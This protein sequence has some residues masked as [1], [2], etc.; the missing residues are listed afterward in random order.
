MKLDDYRENGAHEVRSRISSQNL[1]ELFVSAS[2]FSHD[3]SIQAF[4]PPRC[5]HS[6]TEF[7]EAAT[8]GKVAEQLP[9][10]EEQRVQILPLEEQANLELINSNSFPRDSSTSLPAA[11][12]TLSTDI[13]DAL[14]AETESP[15]SGSNALVKCKST[16][17]P[18]ITISR[19]DNDA[20][21]TTVTTECTDG[22]GCRVPWL[23]RANKV[24]VK[25]VPTK[26]EKLQKLRTRKTK[27]I[28]KLSKSAMKKRTMKPK[29][30]YRKKA[31]RFFKKKAQ[32]SSEVFKSDK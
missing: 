31:L 9:E 4:E 15:Q 5:R 2:N 14:M 6:L 22:P 32:V 28:R 12:P 23:K 30:A 17:V 3:F 7:V 29:R 13:P 20:S 18:E 27:R 11:Q 16:K 1:E 21:E 8:Y 24:T 26:T 19:R 10:I 25:V